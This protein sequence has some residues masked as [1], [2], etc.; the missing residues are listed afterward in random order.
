MAVTLEKSLLFYDNLY[1]PIGNI[2][3]IMDEKGVRKIE[4]IEE[5]WYKFLD[6]N[7]D[8]K[9]DKNRCKAVKNQIDEYFRGE[10]KRF[11]IPLSINSTRF[12]QQVWKELSKIPYG[13]TRSYS[14]IANNIGNPKAVRAI[15]QANKA[16]P[17]P[18]II[19]CHR[20]ISKG[21]SLI[22][23]AGNYTNIQKILLDHE[24]VYK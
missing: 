13:E 11:N 17:L 4:I 5:K 14:E 3:I 19:P 1:T 22:G 12:R 10:R 23:Y 24:K 21:G 6:L 7:S 20:V 15:G 18:I 16:N 9:L 2:C 8:I